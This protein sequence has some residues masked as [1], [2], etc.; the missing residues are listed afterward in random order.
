MSDGKLNMEISEE[1]IRNATTFLTELENILSMVYNT[2]YESSLSAEDL[3]EH[4][5]QISHTR[6][7]LWDALTKAKEC[8]Q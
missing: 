1:T 2:M 5:K 7:E 8:S 4:D 6:D 3:L